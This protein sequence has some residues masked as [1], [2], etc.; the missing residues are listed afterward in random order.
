VTGGIQPQDADGWW[1]YSKCG[2]K[3]RHKPGWEYEKT[4]FNE[5]FPK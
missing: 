3:A 1:T 4:W 5:T 2:L